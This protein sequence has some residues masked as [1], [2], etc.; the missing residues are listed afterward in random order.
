MTSLVWNLIYLGFKG[1][2]KTHQYLRAA[3]D[4]QAFMR[5]LMI[6][7]ENGVVTTKVGLTPD[8]CIEETLLLAYRSFPW[9]ICQVTE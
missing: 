3:G 4:T 2:L 5:L 8:V 6:S 1:F 7:I 9:I